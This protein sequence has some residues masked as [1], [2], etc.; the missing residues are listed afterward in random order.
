MFQHVPKQR[1]LSIAAGAL[2]TTTSLVSI[3]LGTNYPRGAMFILITQQ[4]ATTATAQTINVLGPGG[5]QSLGSY[6]PF[7]FDA[8]TNAIH[9][10]T[11]W[12]ATTGYT[13]GQTIFIQG[14]GNFFNLTHV[15]FYYLENTTQYLGYS[16]GANA[17]GANAIFELLYTIGT[18]VSV[19][20]AYRYSTLEII[21]NTN[22]NGAAWNGL[23]IGVTNSVAPEGGAW[24]SVTNAGGGTLG[25]VNLWSNYL[26]R[27]PTQN[28]GIR[29]RYATAINNSWAFIRFG[30]G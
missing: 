11:V 26:N 24:T 30:G 14:S 12:R 22:P 15:S 25:I 1:I 23:G 17:A 28:T 9:G 21:V 8:A 18:G 5:E 6:G 4:N 27:P 10:W 7:A 2:P 16:T 19:S 13:A 3:T 29:G 20:N